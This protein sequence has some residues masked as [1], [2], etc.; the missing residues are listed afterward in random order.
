MSVLGFSIR[1]FRE[2]EFFEDLRF[3][4]ALVFSK[5]DIASLFIGYINNK[6][7]KHNNNDDDEKI[8]IINK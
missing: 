2:Y 6:K 5:Y 4:S 7:K 8:M 1:S 3:F